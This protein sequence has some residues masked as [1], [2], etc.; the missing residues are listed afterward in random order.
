MKDVADWV[1]AFRASPLR[2]PGC[3]PD[4]LAGLADGIAEVLPEGGTPGAPEL[5]EAEK[6]WTFAGGALAAAG[7]SAFDVMAFVTSLRDATAGDPKLFDWFAAL[8]LEGWGA[9]RLDALRGRTRE[10][11]EKGTPVVQLG[12]GV[13]AALLLG[14]PDRLAVETTLS[15][16]LLLVARTG[17][18]AVVIDAT[19]LIRPDDPAVR[20]GVAAFAR[21]PK[22]PRLA[23][24]VCGLGRAAPAWREAFPRGLRL[25]VEDELAEAVARAESLA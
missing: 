19:G 4:G 2:V 6:R 23:V 14:E 17:A 9:S 7:A 20:E 18:P 15:R 22:L 11:L 24:V 21:H 1:R 25:Y 3:E 13:P 16:L 5:R 8:A 12:R 10:A